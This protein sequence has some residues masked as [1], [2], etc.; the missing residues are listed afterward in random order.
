MHF[1]CLA[2]E[3]QNSPSGTQKAPNAQGAFT[4]LCHLLLEG[5]RET[6]AAVGE[7]PGSVGHVLQPLD[8]KWGRHVEREIPDDV[9]VGWIFGIEIL[10]YFIFFNFLLF[11]TKQLLK[12]CRLSLSN[13]TTLPRLRDGSREASVHPVGEYVPVDNPQ[14]ARRGLRE[15]L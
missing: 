12:G 10:F 7:R 3:P 2:A 5:Q 6:R 4:H 9:E 1:F 14:P 15:Q 11:L 13:L 8:D